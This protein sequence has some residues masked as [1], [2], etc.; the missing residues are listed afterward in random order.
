MSYQHLNSTSDSFE[1]RGKAKKTH[2]R[3]RNSQNKSFIF[4]ALRKADSL[5][6][7][8]PPQKYGNMKGEAGEWVFIVYPIELCRLN[9][10]L[11]VKRG[12]YSKYL[13]SRPLIYSHQMLGREL[14][15]IRGEKQVSPRPASMN[16]RIPASKIGEV[17][18]MA[19]L[20]LRLQQKLLS[21]RLELRFPRARD[22]EFSF[23]L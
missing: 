8:A 1:F 4:C 2:S 15:V 23:S 19:G 10:R 5:A 12:P 17:F 7:Q 16:L 6:S 9:K 22:L 20:R 18:S 21:Y 3:D 14:R 11:P 13:A